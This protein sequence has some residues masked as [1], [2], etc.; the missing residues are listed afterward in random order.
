MMRITRNPT[1]SAPDEPHM[2]AEIINLRQ[3]KK[4]RA[5]ATKE[6]DATANRAKF[7]RTKMERQLTRTES[8][9]E[10]RRLDA[11]KRDQTTGISTPK[12]NS[13]DIVK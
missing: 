5:R 1:T 3:A 13:D 7:G 9:L 2:S 10:A 12:I 8:E 6:A 11:H 4:A